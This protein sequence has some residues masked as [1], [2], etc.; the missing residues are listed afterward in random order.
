MS[1]A[2]PESHG[3][4]AHEGTDVNL[5]PVVVAG[6]G[7][8]LVLIIS[9][10]AMAGLFDILKVEQARSSPQA[11]PLA[12]AEGPQVPPAPRLQVHPIKDLQELRKAE[13]DL[14]TSYGWKDQKTGIVHIPI[15]R[16]MELLAARSPQG[17]ATR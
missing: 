12:A 8:I 1:S 9:A 2:T 16:A 10:L 6:L 11:N 17:A 13:N 15:A 14:L 3:A 7:L 5:R 4:H